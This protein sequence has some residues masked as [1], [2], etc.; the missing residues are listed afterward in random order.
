MKILQII[1]H[2]ADLSFTR[3]L[4]KSFADGA[5]S[6]GHSISLI[7]VYD[8]WTETDVK[9]QILAADHLCFAWPSWW[10]MPPAPLVELLQTVFVKGFAFD[11]KNGRM[12]PLLDLT[13][14]CLVSMG[15]K[16]DYNSYNMG[17]AMRYCGLYPHFYIFNGV[18][19]DL[20]QVKKEQY[21]NMAYFSGSKLRDKLCLR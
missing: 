17:D 7:D 2:P 9:D 4:A 20:S 1:A 14:T 11:L 8:R 12:Q 13:T 6:K 19:P 18:G 15:Q 5:I 10:E 21:L 3:A 16:K